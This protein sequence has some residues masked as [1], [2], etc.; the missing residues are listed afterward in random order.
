MINN[1]FYNDYGNKWYTA[2]DD[3]VA[4][5]RAEGKLKQKWV[6]DRIEPNRK[7]LDVGCGAGFLCNYLASVGH[8]VT[9][10]DLSAPSIEVAKRHDSTKSV[11]YICGDAYNLPFPDG[12]FDVVT[13]MDFLEHV[14][15]PEKSIKECSRVLRPGGKF[16]F[17]TFNRNWISHLV[18]IKAVERFIK[19]T[20]KDMH[21]INLFLKPEEVEAMCDGNRLKVSEW[22]GLRPE[23]SFGLLKIA[24]TGRVPID[25]AFT[26]TRSRAISYM[27][28]A[29]RI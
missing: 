16:F 12:Q 20:P 26:S 1:D 28:L 23:F 3:P 29:N 7:I 11:Q 27:G 21:V 6:H 8:S 17:H 5:L 9:G 18:V 4:L 19:N 14:D 25:L 15:D 22:T 10:L 2:F 24:W 13:N